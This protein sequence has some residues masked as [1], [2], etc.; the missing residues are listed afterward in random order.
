[1][2]ETEEGAC[3]A[4]CVKQMDRA[5]SRDASAMG[6]LMMVFF[7]FFFAAWDYAPRGRLL[8]L[9]PDGRRDP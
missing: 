1:M 5:A 3:P 6:T 7:F 4:G 2:A 9:I 8:T